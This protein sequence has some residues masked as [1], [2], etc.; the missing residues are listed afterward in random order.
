MK[1][2]KQC[3]YELN[4]L[5]PVIKPKVTPSKKARHGLGNGYATTSGHS[6]GSETF[7]V[8]DLARAEQAVDELLQMKMLESL[9]DSEPG[10]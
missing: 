2:A 7:S 10:T 1:E 8:G 4:I 3:D 6:S 5:E 9:L